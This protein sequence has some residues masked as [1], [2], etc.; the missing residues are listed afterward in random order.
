MYFLDDKV[1]SIKD[2]LFLGTGSEV[3]VDGN[4]R[5][6]RLPTSVVLISNSNKKILINCSP[7]VTEQFKRENIDI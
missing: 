1:D 2:V 7:Y 3:P 5:D 6:R 4:G